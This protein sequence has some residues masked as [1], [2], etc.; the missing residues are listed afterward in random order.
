VDKA[1]RV[2]DKKTDCRREHFYSTDYGWIFAAGVF[3]AGSPQWWDFEL[4]FPNNPTQFSCSCRVLHNGEILSCHSQTIPH[5]SLVHV[6]EGNNF[7][8]SYSHSLCSSRITAQEKKL[9]NKSSHTLL[10]MQEQSSLECWFN[11][12]LT[13]PMRDWSLTMPNRNW[14]KDLLCKPTLWNLQTSFA[15]LQVGQTCDDM[16][17]PC[18]IK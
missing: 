10:L 16:E 7:G 14:Y 5:N 8:R 6:A 15:L 13:I 3:V 11:Q 17:C 4:P 18:T 12:S 1:A 2:Q 9:K